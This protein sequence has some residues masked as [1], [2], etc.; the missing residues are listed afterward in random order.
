MIKKITIQGLRGFGKECT[1]EFS[2]PK[3]VSSMD[4]SRDQNI[5]N[6]GSGMTI[7]V[8]SNNSGKTT[9]L[10]ALRAFNSQKDNP[11]S[12]SERKRNMKCQK[13]KVH[14]KLETES[15][16]VYTIDTVE[17]GG[18]ETVMGKKGCRDELEWSAPKIFVLQSRR[19]VEF[20]FYHSAME[21][22]EYIQTQQ[23]KTRTHILNDFSARL[24]KMYKNKKTFNELL[25]R[26]LGYDFEWTIEQNDNGTFYLKFI[27]NNCVHS[28]EGV[29]DG[30]WSV[31]TI[32]DA[33]YDSEPGCT[34]AVDEPELSLHPAYQKRIMELFK[35]FS[36][37]RQIII[38]THSPY[39]ID[40]ESITKGAS[41]Y[42]TVKNTDGNIEVYKLLEQ[43][44]KDLAGF[45]D[46]INQ[47]HTLGIEAK[48]IFFLEDNVILTEGQED[49]IM[50]KKACK[51]VSIPLHGNFF[52]WGSSGASNIRKIASI[53][54]NLGYQKVV[55]IFDGDML[56]EKKKFEVDFPEYC[57]QIISMP[58]IR[59]KP[60]TSAKKG[61]EG[62]MKQDGTIKEEHKDEIRMLFKSINSYFKTVKTADGKS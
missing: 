47:P 4:D 26:V 1:I 17:S 32:C 5:D 34:I 30:I 15:N 38:S 46:N 61:K 2:I 57:S 9:I 62:M 29:G 35:E 59:D 50:Y 14:L 27:V 54:R 16:E 24:F 60:P 55:A 49:V 19:S 3:T 56:A 28:S 45:L 33:L 37:D 44:R 36:K 25:G 31:F 6:L 52:G 20:E 41:L 18:S 21:R 13:G 22:D 11:P 39:F 7:F 43:N 40:F 53:L 48:E 12:F 42:R 23:M 58:D 10:E 51:E 8:G